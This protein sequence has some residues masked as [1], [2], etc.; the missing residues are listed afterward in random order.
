MIVNFV[1]EVHSFPPERR[2][3]F[4]DWSQARGHNWSKVSD[5]DRSGCLHVTASAR[6]Y[7]LQQLGVVTGEELPSRWAA[8][9]RALS[10]LA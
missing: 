7:A 6:Y 8:R 9:F 10:R 1:P 4:T 2:L 5:E 3:D